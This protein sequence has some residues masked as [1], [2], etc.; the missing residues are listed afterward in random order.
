[1]KIKLPSLLAFDSQ[2][3]EEL[4]IL[5][6]GV[7][8][9]FLFLPLL[10]HIYAGSFMRLNGDDYCYGGT[11]MQYG[12]WGGQWYAYQNI[13]RLYLGD[14]YSLNLVEAIFNLFAPKMYP[15][16]LGAG[17]ILWMVCLFF[18]LYQ[19]TKYAGYRVHFMELI[20][21][22]TALLFFVFC[23][24]KDVT[25]LLY[26]FS[27][28]ATYIYPMIF[29]VLLMGLI[30]WAAHSF[31]PAIHIPLIFLTA[32]IGGGF[33]ETTAVLQLGCIILLVLWAGLMSRKKIQKGLI[34]T[35]MIALVSTCGSI[36]LL[37][38]SPSTK[39]RLMVSQHPSVFETVYLTIKFSLAFFIMR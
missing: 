32:F 35:A 20:F 37:A 18:F 12:F 9:I 24:T 36:L 17:I 6:I 8:S 29:I 31:I 4:F 21:L 2:K 26:W 5:A 25:Q 16:F 11:Q 14:R 38:L 30:F 22:S 39:D 15:V 34:I 13:G 1:M 19:F 27:G 10:F 7:C 28:M 33:S 23:V 3:Q